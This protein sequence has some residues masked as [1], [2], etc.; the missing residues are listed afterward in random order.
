MPKNT[1]KAFLKA[2]NET[3]EGKE[4]LKFGDYGLSTLQDVIKKSLIYQDVQN[5]HILDEYA[6][7]TIRKSFEYFKGIDTSTFSDK[8]REEFALFVEAGEKFISYLG[9]NADKA[10]LRSNDTSTLYPPNKAMSLQITITIEQNY[11][12]LFTQKFREKSQ[13]NNDILM[14]LLK[15]VDENAANSQNS[16]NSSSQNEQNKFTQTSLNLTQN[17][18]TQNSA[19]LTQNE[20]TQNAVNLN[21]QN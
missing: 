15:S 19:N 2:L 17:K 6:N 11:S 4:S 10:I 13:Q 7:Y 16:L 9:S 12:L 14:S 8:Q 18:F 5:P 1:Q 3:Y 21:S 20:F